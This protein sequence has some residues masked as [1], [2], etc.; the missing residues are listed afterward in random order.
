MHA[1][2][3][4]PDCSHFYFSHSPPP[5]TPRRR[6]HARTIDN[7]M[8]TDT[9][10]DCSRFDSLHSPATITPSTWLHH[11]HHPTHTHIWLNPSKQWIEIA[12]FSNN[13]Q[14]LA[15]MSLL[16]SLCF[17]MNEVN[18]ASNFSNDQVVNV[19]PWLL[20]AICHLQLMTNIKSR[21]WLTLNN[22]MNSVNL[23]QNEWSEWSFK[24]QQWSSC[25]CVALTSLCYL[26]FAI[27]DDKYKITEMINTK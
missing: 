9:T 27:I 6:H 8:H 13:D 18:E 10:P 23:F 17:K 21:K 15:I 14:I 7:T 26:P 2:T 12:N 25:K 16:S 3:K 22:G 5:T 20:F 4:T 19:L 11:L 1:D 24:F